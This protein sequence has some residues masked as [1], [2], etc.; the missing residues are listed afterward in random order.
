MAIGC[1]SLSISVTVMI[2]SQL[3][4]VNRLYEKRFSRYTL[5]LEMTGVSSVASILSHRPR[6]S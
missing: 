4:D 2:M 1:V 6:F 5:L 3:D